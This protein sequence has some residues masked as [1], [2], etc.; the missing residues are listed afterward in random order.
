M[1]PRLELAGRGLCAVPDAREKTAR[2]VGFGHPRIARVFASGWSAGR[3]VFEIEIEDDRGPTLRDSAA[4]LAVD[5]D[6]ISATDR[7]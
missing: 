2:W 3:V 1:V 5:A 6:H 7:N 4:Q